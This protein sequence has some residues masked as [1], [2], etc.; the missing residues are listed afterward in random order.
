[1]MDEPDL[2]QAS[3]AEL[4][5]LYRRILSELRRRGVLRT[6]NPPVGEYAEWL[7][8]RATGGLLAANPSQ[9]SWDVEAP[10][11]ELLQVKSRFVTSPTNAGERQLSPFRSWEFDAAV[12]VLF[13]DEFTV[14]RAAK[15]PRSVVE[16]ASADNPYVGGRRVFAT[17]GLLDRGEDWTGLLKAA[18]EETA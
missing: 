9:S 1:M 18:A 15:V 10:D 14:W 5:R 8:V 11:G 13:D 12:I 17:N 3:V 4:G 16:G 2:S 7:V 6:G